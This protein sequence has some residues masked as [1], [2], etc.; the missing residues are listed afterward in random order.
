MLSISSPLECSKSNVSFHSFCQIFHLTKKCRADVVVSSRD[1]MQ[2]SE[3]TQFKFVS[4]V[5]SSTSLQGVQVF[6]KSEFVL[7]SYVFL[8]VTDH[9]VHG[10]IN[11]GF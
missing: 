9:A 2:L 3:H 7:E 4:R 1:V 6:V 11:F 8:V 10:H 5:T